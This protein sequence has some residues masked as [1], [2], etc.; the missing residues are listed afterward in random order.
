MV[1]AAG[2]RWEVNVVNGD[3]RAIDGGINGLDLEVVVLYGVCAVGS[4]LYGVVNKEGQTTT[5]T[6]GAIPTDEGVVREDW[7]GGAVS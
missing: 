3:G 5:R 7:F 1:R 2:A 6:A 4:V